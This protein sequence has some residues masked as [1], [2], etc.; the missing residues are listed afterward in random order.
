MFTGAAFT[1]AGTLAIR[2]TDRL[3]IFNSQLMC[4]GSKPGAGETEARLPDDCFGDF[5]EDSVKRPQSEQ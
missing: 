3:L 2:E 4:H 1:A 5:Q